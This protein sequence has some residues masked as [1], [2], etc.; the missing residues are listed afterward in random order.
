MTADWHSSC[1]PVFDMHNVS[2]FKFYF[3]MCCFLL[4]NY[5]V[6]ENTSW[7]HLRNSLKQ[8]LH[9]IM[10]FYGA[11][12]R[13]YC[14]YMRGC[15]RKCLSFSYEYS[16][17]SALQVSWKGL[18]RCSYEGEIEKFHLHY[19]LQLQYLS[20]LESS[21]F[22][23]SITKILLVEDVQWVGV[24]LKIRQKDEAEI[25]HV[26]AYNAMLNTSQK[27]KIN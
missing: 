20:Y 7:C 22:C 5:R 25:I 17:S 15:E 24:D 4:L 14:V 19:C 23:K 13:Y 8:T 27:G 16:F 2:F 11:F 12:F 9:K 10:L 6:T 18:W 21:R 1:S 3:S 26:E